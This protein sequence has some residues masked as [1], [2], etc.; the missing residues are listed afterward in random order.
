MRCLP[1]LFVASLGVLL[2]AG[3]AATA[4]TAPQYPT[5][6][7][8]REMRKQD[9]DEC[10]GQA[11]QENL[12]ERNRAGFIRKCMANRQG[13]RRAAAK[14][15]SSENRRLQREMA[16]EEWS[17]IVDV[18]NQER[19]ELLERQAT[20]RAECNKQAND[21]KLRLSRRRSFIKECVAQ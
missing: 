11:M 12:A 18:R 4:Q 3:D 15:K 20:K 9:R 19:R 7:N 13:A 5:P 2:V 1:A 10:T 17:A 21:Q 16:G 6:A 8:S 14:K